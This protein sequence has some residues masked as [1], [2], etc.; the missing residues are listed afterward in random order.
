MSNALVFTMSTLKLCLMLWSLLCLMLFTMSTLKLCLMLWSLHLSKYTS[1][2]ILTDSVNWELL[3]MQ[4]A[5]ALLWHLI[6]Y[7]TA[8]IGSIYIKI[9][10][11]FCCCL[12]S[13]CNLTH[14]MA[15]GSQ[16]IAYFLFKICKV[17]LGFL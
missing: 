10:T 16:G 11:S 14:W 2:I 3:I 1:L 12:L 9:H 15:L 5:Q 4:T 8:I 7:S 13:H 6:F 17:C